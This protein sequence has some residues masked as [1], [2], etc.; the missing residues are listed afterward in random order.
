[1]L[2]AAGAEILRDDSVMFA[3]ALRAAGVAVEL[4]VWPDLF[5]VFEFAWRFLPQSED[6]IIKMGDFVRRHFANKQ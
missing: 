2:Q 4:D 5:H 3:A 1:M 6:A